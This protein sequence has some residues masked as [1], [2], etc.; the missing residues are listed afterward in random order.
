[1]NFFRYIAC[2]FLRNSPDFFCFE[3]DNDDYRPHAIDVI[4]EFA[5]L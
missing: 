3:S 4:R 1:M 2:I 5:M